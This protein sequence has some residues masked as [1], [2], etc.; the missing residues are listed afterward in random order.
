MSYLDAFKRRFEKL[1]RTN[2]WPLKSQEEKYLAVFTSGFDAGFSS[3][4]AKVYR[5]NPTAYQQ[6][7]DKEIKKKIPAQVIEKVAVNE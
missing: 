5:D 1:T 2:K 7:V 4:E 3:C 6:Y